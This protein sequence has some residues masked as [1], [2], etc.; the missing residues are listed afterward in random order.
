MSK[1]NEEP[2]GDTRPITESEKDKFKTNI[3]SEKIQ[4]GTLWIARCT[5]PRRILKAW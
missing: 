3:A 5:S 1:Y 2:K 4:P